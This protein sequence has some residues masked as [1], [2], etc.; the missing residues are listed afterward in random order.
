MS[1]TEHYRHYKQAIMHYL[2]YML[3]VEPSLSYLRY[4]GLP[5]R[6]HDDHKPTVDECGSL[7]QPPT[8]SREIP[9]AS[10]A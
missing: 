10:C 7:C 3:L 8:R 2:R 9:P 6:G 4:S 5:T 1:D